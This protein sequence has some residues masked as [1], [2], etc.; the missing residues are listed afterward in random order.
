LALAVVFVALSIFAVL[1]FGAVRL[2]QQT[3]T[4][5]AADASAVAAEDSL[6]GLST[7]FPCTVA[8]QL[9]EE[10]G[11]KMQSCRIV[12]LEVF[13]T[14]QSETLGIVLSARARAGVQ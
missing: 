10:N 2:L 4:Q 8:K 12:N 7:G 5:A 14:V 11:M 3:R 13:I 6:R 1:Q 9:V